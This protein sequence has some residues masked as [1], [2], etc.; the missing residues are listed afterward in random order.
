MNIYLYYVDVSYAS[1]V[2]DLH[3]VLNLLDTE[4]LAFSTSYGS[5]TVYSEQS[6][7]DLAHTFVTK[8][9]ATNGNS[10]KTHYWFKQCEQCGLKVD[11]PR[12][13]KPH[14]WTDPNGVNAGRCRE[15]WTLCIHEWSNGVCTNCGYSC[16][17]SFCL[18][19][20]TFVN[21]FYHEDLYDC[22]ICDYSYIDIQ[23]HVFA[24]GDIQGDNADDYKCEHC[25]HYVIIAENYYEI[26]YNQGLVDGADMDSGSIAE[27]FVFGIYDGMT[28]TF[29]S[30]LGYEILGVNIAQLIISLIA[31][32]LVVF[33]VKKVI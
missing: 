23:Q 31:I 32:A 16:S 15:C 6:F 9:W 24:F 3:D 28:N 29:F 18:T 12:G 1:I 4:D 5:S 30:M 13:T 26:G 27:G 2:D 8:C 14:I 20:Q 33:V 7:S 25:K 11:D 17:H 19:S 21:T 10:N 22:S